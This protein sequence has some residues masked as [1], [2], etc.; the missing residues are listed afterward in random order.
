MKFCHDLIRQLIDVLDVGGGQ[1]LVARAGLVY[2]AGP[3]E[4]RLC[5][6]MLCEMDVVQDTDHRHGFFGRES[7]G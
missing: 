3:H 4:Y 5:G 2:G 1:R 7:A 6:V